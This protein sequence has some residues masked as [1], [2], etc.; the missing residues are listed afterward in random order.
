MLIQNVSG[1]VQAPQSFRLTSDG[2]P[3]VAD[4]PVATQETVKQPSDQQVKVAVDSINQALKQADKSLQLSIDPSTK[5]PVVKMIDSQT[6]ELVRQ[7]PTKE[8]LAI[9]QGIDQFLKHQGTLF[10]QEA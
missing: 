7:Y 4:V 10:K 3:K 1:A 2:A 6:G 8:V 5:S 9:A